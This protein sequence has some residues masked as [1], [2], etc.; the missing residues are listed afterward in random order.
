MRTSGTASW[1][2]AGSEPSL[3]AEGGCP[4]GIGSTVTFLLQP[5]TNWLYIDEV[6]LT[7]PGALIF[8]ATVNYTTGTVSATPEP[9]SFV[10]LGA[11]GLLAA[12]AYGMRKSLKVANSMLS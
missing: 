3:Y 7:G 11:T 5:G 1:R 12:L 10:L 4:T 8:S 9:S 6:N 2:V